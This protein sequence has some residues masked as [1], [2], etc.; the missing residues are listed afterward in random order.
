M[1]TGIITTVAGTSTGGYG[2]DG[3]PATAALLDQPRGVAIDPEGNLYIA[4]YFN[5]TVRKVTAA[6]GIITTIA[7]S[8]VGGYSTHGSYAGD[9]GQATAA[10]F[11]GVEGVA[12]DSHGNVYVADQYNNRIRRIDAVTGIITTVVGIGPTSGLGGA[13]VVMVGQQQ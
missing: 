12:L 9:G 13:I 4:E 2:G 7:G 5:N 11:D 8:P 10:L 6:T 3:G 1:S